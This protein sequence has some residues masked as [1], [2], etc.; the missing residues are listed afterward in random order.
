[1]KRVIVQNTNEGLESLLGEKVTLLCT[2]YIYTGTLSGLNDNF[3]LLSDPSIVYETGA[4]DKK[5]WADV[6]ALPKKEIYI[7]LHSIESFGIMK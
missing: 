5:D 6:Q 7:M 4:W 2:R 1:M 3:C